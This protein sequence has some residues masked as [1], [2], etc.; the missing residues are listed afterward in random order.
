MRISDWSSDV[1]S[2]DLQDFYFNSRYAD[3]RGQPGVCDFTFGNPQEFPLPGLVQALH[4]QADLQSES[5]Y[6]YKTNEADACAFL[7][8]SLSRELGLAFAPAD[9][10]MTPGAFGAIALAFRLLLTPGDEV[11]IPLPGWFCYGSMLAAEG[12]DRKSTRLNSS[13]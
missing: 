11:L 9:I 1:C 6:A 5:W 12:V 8:E 3:R 7:A 10:A 13:H 2:S 4:R